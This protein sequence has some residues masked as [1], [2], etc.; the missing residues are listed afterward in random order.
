M[1][2]Q[3]SNLGFFLSFLS[4]SSASNSILWLQLGKRFCLVVASKISWLLISIFCWCVFPIL[5]LFFCIYNYVSYIK[6]PIYLV[7]MLLPNIEYHCFIP[8]NCRNL[9]GSV[10]CRQGD[11]I[12]WYKHN[13][14]YIIYLQHESGWMAKALKHIRRRYF[15]LIKAAQCKLIRNMSGTW[16]IFNK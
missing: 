4:L 5:H 1:T 2:Q 3:H 10:S 16:Y 6:N 8:D 11:E 12:L 14:P 7:Y 9:S 13:H 15:K